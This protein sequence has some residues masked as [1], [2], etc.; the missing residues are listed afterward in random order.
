MT[1]S[2]YQKGA[3]GSEIRHTVQPCWLG[4]VLV[5][6]TPKGICAIAFGDAPERLTAQLQMD[7]PK[8]QFGQSDP[9]F[10]AWVEQILSLIEA[11]KYPVDLPLDILGTAF[12]QQ[13]W[14]ALRAIA[15]GT[16]L[17]YAEV[18]QCI[19]KPKAIRA[20]ANACA[21]NQIAVAIPCHRVIGRDGR[22][23][24]YRWGRDRKQIGRAHV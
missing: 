19:G 9:E 1:P 20:V 18:A 5:V 14:E 23:K 8:A 15:P 7:F 16:T 2:Q 10:E 11:P 17:S 22:L 21:S 6:A 4:W 3:K 13:V 12:Q 24:D